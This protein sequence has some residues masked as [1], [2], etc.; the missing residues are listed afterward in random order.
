MGKSKEKQGDS[1]DKLLLF[2]LKPILRLCIRR[3]IKLQTIIATVKRGLVEVAREELERVDAHVSVTRISVMTGMYRKDIQNLIDT[4]L[5]KPGR[6]PFLA[7]LIGQ[8]RNH[9]TYCRKPGEPKE[10]DCTGKE[11]DFFALV[12]SVNKEINPYAVLFE[13][14]RLGIA[15]N[16][17]G[18]LKLLVSEL[19]SGTDIE[20]GLKLLGDDFED[21]IRIIEHNTNNTS[22]PEHV[23]QLHLKTVYDNVVK[24]AIPAIRLW[25]LK[26]GAEFHRRARD[27]IS[28]YDKDLNPALHL[29]EGGAKTS[30]GTFSASIEE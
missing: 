24:S 16:E 21:L 11:S 26:E 5:E 1:S 27:F 10:L 4:A 15:V 2:I 17:E 19:A 14:E 9:K 12:A 13:L 29:E 8:W 6:M 22:S 18:K 28:Q 25:I 7:R 3:A 20:G 23:P 30:I